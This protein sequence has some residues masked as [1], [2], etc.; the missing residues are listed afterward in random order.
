MPA[1]LLDGVS[2]VALPILAVATTLYRRAY[3]HEA[4]QRRRL[5]QAVLDV[6]NRVRSEFLQTMSHELRTPLN[7]IIGFANILRKNR[8]ET[9]GEQE[10]LYASRIADNGKQLLKLVDDLL[11]LAALEAGRATFALR[12]IAVRDLLTSVERLVAPLARAEGVDLVVNVADA[13]V[14][15]TAD[16]E[17]AR[18]ILLNLATNAVTFTPEGGTVVVSCCQRDGWAHIEVRDSGRGM[19][20]D[21]VVAMFEPFPSAEHTRGQPF[22]DVGLR[23]TISRT[24][25]RGMG[26]ELDAVST[27]GEGS[28]FTLH[29]PL[30]R[31]TDGNAGFNE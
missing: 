24:L 10:L 16:V 19:L 17:R 29:L 3:R 15:V 31:A 26:G 18:Q 1:H 28:A 8:S 6:G 9:L 13:S 27:V 12:S 20:P 22:G 14:F 23:L 2:L 11:H 30:A 7:A 5:E 4:S 25:A 21:E